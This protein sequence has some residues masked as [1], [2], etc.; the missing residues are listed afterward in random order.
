MGSD[1]TQEALSRYGQIKRIAVVTPYMP[2]GDQQVVKFFA[3]C[4]L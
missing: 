2:V 1:A 4:G 3:D